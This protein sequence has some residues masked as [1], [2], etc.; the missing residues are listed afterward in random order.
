MSSSSPGAAWQRPELVM[1]FLDERG[2]VLPLI[3]EQEDLIRRIF[4]R[5]GHH[6]ERFLDVGSG[7]GAMSEVLL[8]LEPEAEAVL[9]DFSEPMLGRAERRLGSYP[10]RWKAVRGDLSDPT[11]PSSLPPGGYDAAISALAIH[12]LP[13]ERK[14]ALFRELFELLAPGA[15]FVNMDYVS[16]RG[17]LEGLWDEQTVANALRAERERGGSRSEEEIER[18]LLADDEDDR[19]DSAEDQL[20]WLRRAGFEGVELHFKWAEAAIFG[21]VKPSGRVAERREAERREGERREAERREG[22]S[23]AGERRAGER[24]AG[25]R[26]IENPV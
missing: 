19:P 7:D 8:G 20:D 16:V 18:E 1:E 10:R 14:R 26:Q 15:L 9:V 23:R 11:W 22:E 3:G 2:V 6:L 13:A 25:E 24:R 12:H 5:H 4:E 21:A 17:P